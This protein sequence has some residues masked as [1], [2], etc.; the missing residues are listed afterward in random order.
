MTECYCPRYWK[1]EQGSAN[2]LT[3]ALL[4]HH[5]EKAGLLQSHCFLNIIP[6]SSL[7]NANLGCRLFHVVR[8]R[9]NPMISEMKGHVAMTRC[10]R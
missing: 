5:L 3:S 10:F 9:I 6:P 2:D 4:D 8:C 1:T 7:N